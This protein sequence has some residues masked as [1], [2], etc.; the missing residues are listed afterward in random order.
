MQSSSVSFAKAKLS[1]ASICNLKLEGGLGITISGGLDSCCDPIKGRWFWLLKVPQTLGTFDIVI[2][3]TKRM[4]L[5]QIA[6][7]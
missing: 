7:N 4:I 3:K 1:W 6:K 2:F 5:N